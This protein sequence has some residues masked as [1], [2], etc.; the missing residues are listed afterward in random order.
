MALHVQ[1]RSPLAIAGHEA[2]TV[3]LPWG[4][5]GFIFPWN[6]PFQLSLVP[7]ISALIAGNVAILKPSELTLTV[8]ELIERLMRENEEFLKAKQAHTQ[9][10]RQLEELEN[11]SFITSLHGRVREIVTSFQKGYRWLSCNRSLPT[12]YFFFLVEKK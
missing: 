5:C 2:S 11:K 12:K 4:P 9:L 7:L 8:G 10:A 1:R 3:R 6:F